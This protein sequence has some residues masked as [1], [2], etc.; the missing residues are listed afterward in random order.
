LFR[1]SV[2]PSRRSFEKENAN[3]HREPKHVDFA[4]QGDVLPDMP[5]VPDYLLIVRRG[6]LLILLILSRKRVIMHLQQGARADYAKK[7]KDYA[8]PIGPKLPQASPLYA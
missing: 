2:S 3:Q 7:P 6:G 1:H 4:K 5:D 8:T